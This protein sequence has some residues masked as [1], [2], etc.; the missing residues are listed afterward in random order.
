MVMSS[1]SDMPV[2][3]HEITEL[4][5]QLDQNCADTVKEESCILLSSCN[6]RSY[7]PVES[8][9]VAKVSIWERKRRCGDS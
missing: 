2:I 1:E 6:P 7:A 5:P 4:W 3:S 9:L 8:S